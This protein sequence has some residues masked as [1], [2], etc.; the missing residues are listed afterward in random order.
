MKKEGGIYTVPCKVNDLNLRFVFDTGASSVCISLSEAV[1]MFK[2][3][4]LDSSDIVGSSSSTIADGSLVENT[5]I[6][7]REIEVGGL[8]LYNVNAVVM[9]N[10]EAPL[11]LGQSAIQ[12]LGTVQVQGDELIILNGKADR[13]A[14]KRPMG[15]YWYDIDIDEGLRIEIDLNSIKRENDYIVHYQKTVYIDK[16]LKKQEIGKILKIKNWKD[17]QCEIAKYVFDCRKRK[18][19]L[20][21][22]TVYGKSG[23]VIGSLQ[24]NERDWRDISPET[25][26]DYMLSMLCKQYEIFYNGESY[27]MYIEDAVPFLEQY[28]TATSSE[29]L[30]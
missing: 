12:K 28:P 22:L 11:L 3:G 9:H 23:N 5:R 21:G 25:R 7:L 2:N 13:P 10:L 29:K 8:K 6:I 27:R 20:L 17:Y 14:I 18:V 30:K 26:W 16:K 24:P 15:V 19:D 1:F 4:Y